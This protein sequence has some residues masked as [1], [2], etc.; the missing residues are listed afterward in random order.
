MKIASTNAMAFTYTVSY[1]PEDEEFVG[2]CEKFPGMSW[3]AGSQE[4]ALKGIVQ[5]VEEILEEYPEEELPAEEL[6]KRFDNDEDVSEFFDFTTSERINSTNEQGSTKPDK[7]IPLNENR[8][9][10]LPTDWDRT[11]GDDL[12]ERQREMQQ[13]IRRL[14]EGRPPK[15]TLNDLFVEALKDPELAAKWNSLD[16]GRQQK[17]RKTPTQKEQAESSPEKSQD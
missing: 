15:W 12:R 14:K 4:E 17:H 1:S 9:T 3:L 2:T 11:E 7:V 10:I 8:E 6:D 13:E 16:P 5:A